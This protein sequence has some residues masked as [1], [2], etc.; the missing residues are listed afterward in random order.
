[1]LMKRIV[2][3]LNMDLGKIQQYAAALI[4]MVLKNSLCLNSNIGMHWCVALN[5]MI[6]CMKSILTW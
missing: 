3:G 2:I 4:Y 5:Y 6:R 1:M